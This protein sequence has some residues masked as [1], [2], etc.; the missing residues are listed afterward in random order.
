MCVAL[1][2]AVSAILFLSAIHNRAI[3]KLEA[4]AR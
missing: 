4:I 1:I 2:G 3:Q